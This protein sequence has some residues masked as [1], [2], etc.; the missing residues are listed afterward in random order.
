MKRKVKT[1]AKWIKALLFTALV[2]ILFI[3]LL[4][5][6]WFL[7]SFGGVDFATVVYQ[8]SSPMQGTSTEI[9]KEYCYE[10]LYPSLVMTVIFCGFY[11]MCNI[12]LQKIFYR[13]DIRIGKLSG[14]L[15]IDRN[16]WRGARI[17]I[18]IAG[19]LFFGLFITRNVIIMDI[20]GY[21]MD[22]TD[23]SSIFEEEYVNPQSVTIE[24]PEE[25]RNLLLIY[26]ESMETTYASEDAGGAK[27][28]NYIPELTRLAEENVFFSNTAKLGGAFIYTGTGWTMAALL[29]SSAGVPYKLPIEGNSAGE[30]ESFLPGI[31][32]LGDILQR[33][34]YQNYF[35]CG[36]EAAFGGREAFY[37]QH[38]DYQIFDYDSAREE[39]VI[40]QDYKV[41]WGMEDE[42]LY[43]YARKKLTE[44]GETGEP[45]NFTMLTVDTHHPVG[46]KCELCHDEYPE[47][48]ANSIACAS[49]QAADF[50]KWTKQ[51]PW[52][53]NTT[54]ILVGDH[55]SMNADFWEDIGD[56]DRRTYNCFLNLPD[57]ILKEDINRYNRE[58]STMDFFP[59]VLA[60]LNVKIEG[61]KLGL[62]TNLFSKEPTLPEKMGKEEFSEQLSKYSNYYYTEFIVDD[63]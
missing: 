14:K 24:F 63:E 17:V 37:E 46:Y 20:P 62:G 50:V 35:M 18:W 9:L 27:A 28:V 53:E 5:S 51:Q 38:G 2:F 57:E 22:I 13:I 42:K 30:Y 11:Y 52:Y 39:E 32:S 23:S 12:L 54:I 41:Y 48:F 44:L 1:A 6:N 59:T 10:C 61:D 25:K 55:N 29:A 26:L 15:K 8:L 43:A 19:G 58:F 21:L 40:S 36:S 33:E 49:R 3:V 47:Q 31:I 60:S 45:F 34:G 56:Y 4:S 16:L 7:K